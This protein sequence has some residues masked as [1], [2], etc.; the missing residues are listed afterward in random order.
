[1]RMKSKEMK[2]RYFIALSACV[3]LI[4]FFNVHS[5]A[6]R[7]APCEQHLLIAKTMRMLTSRCKCSWLL[8]WL[9]A[10]IAGRPKGTSH[11]VVAKPARIAI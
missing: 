6:G 7:L 5:A 11:I 1:M 2:K 9:C 3:G 10:G 4:L 8:L